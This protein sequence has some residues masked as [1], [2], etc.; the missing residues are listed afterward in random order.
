MPVNTIAIPAA[1]A[2]AMTSASRIEPPGWMTAVAPASIAAT[3]PSA[4]GKKASEATTEPLRARRRPAGSARRVL[5]LARGDRARNRRATSAPRR[6][7]R[8]A[9]SLR[10]DD[11]VR[12]DVLADPPGEG[13][14]GHLGR[15][16]RALGDDLRAS[17]DRARRRRG[18][19]PAGRRRPSARSAVGARGS[20]SAPA[21]SRRRF[22][23]VA[24]I[25]SASSSTS[26][27]MITSVKIS[28]ILRAA[29][30]SSVRLS[31]T[32]PP[33]AETGSHDS[34]FS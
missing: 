7:R 16:R 11:R 12:F 26:G 24:T 22:F 25:A 20:G 30:A 18:P 13:E 5:G 17:R 14:I 29:A 33:K 10:V 9:P 31:A 19:A 3:S 15:G 4:K 32:T 1:S 2:A 28:T 8:S 23:L 27:A 6:R 34:A 21:T